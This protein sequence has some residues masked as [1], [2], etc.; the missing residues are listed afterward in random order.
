MS[1]CFAS[2]CN[3]SYQTPILLIPPYICDSLLPSAWYTTT[4]GTRLHI[5]LLTIRQTCSARKIASSH[6]PSFTSVLIYIVFTHRIQSVKKCLRTSGIQLTLDALLR[7]VRPSAQLKSET[8]LRKTRNGLSVDRIQLVVSWSRPASKS[9]LW[10]CRSHVLRVC[11]SRARV[12]L[13]SYAESPC[14]LCHQST[15]MTSRKTETRVMLVR[16]GISPKRIL[17]RH[18]LWQPRS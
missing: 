7:I 8:A 17:R 12:S 13:A 10:R 4:P 14:T 6:A 11:W 15:A 18:A 9:K 5:E 2:C 1:K 3:V 16:P